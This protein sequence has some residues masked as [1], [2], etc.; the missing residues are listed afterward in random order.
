MH[1]Q[2]YAANNNESTKGVLPVPEKTVLCKNQKQT[3][4]YNPS[5]SVF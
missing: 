1:V 3:K 5:F 2:L 4:N